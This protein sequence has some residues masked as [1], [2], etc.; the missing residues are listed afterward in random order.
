MLEKILFIYFYR[1]VRGGRKRKRN[2][3]VQE[4]HE[5]VAFHTPLTGDLAYCPNRE[6]NP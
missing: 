1:E 6:S 4:T 3:I 5:L 2:I